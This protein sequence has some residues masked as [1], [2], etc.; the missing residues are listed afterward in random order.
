[1]RLFILFFMIHELLFGALTFATNH[2]KEIDILKSFDIDSSFLYDKELEKIIKDNRKIYKTKHFFKAMD[3]A[4]LFIPMIKNIL[5]NSDVPSEF[6]FLAM[7]ESYFST[8]AYS[9]KRASGL[10]QF[11]PETGRIYGLEINEYIDERRDLVKSTA[12]AV[13]YLEKE[14][15]RFGKWYLAALSYNCGGGRVAR[16][17]KRAGTDDLSVLLDPKKRY[18]PKESRRYIRKIIALALLGTDESFLVES[19]YEFL[20]NRA[21]A[22]SVAAVEVQKGES[23]SRIAKILEMPKKDILKLNRQLKYDFVP[24][25]KDKYTIYIPHVKLSQFKQNYKPSNIEQVYVVYRVKSGDSLYKIGKRYGV[26]Y[27]LIKDFNHLKSNR[28]SLRQKLIIPVSRPNA[29][30]GG[31]YTVKRGD[32]LQSIAHTYKLSIKQLKQI[33]HLKGDMIRI[34]EKLA[35]YD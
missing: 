34:G 23:I 33:N 19:E 18:L 7:T 1:M 11:M 13:K 28:L 5:S 12:A 27:R 6:L 8:K 16:A 10:W 3:D 29:L 35:V 21:N 15:K 2:Q 25:N 20:L 22:Y 32:T 30:K 31:R 9:Q 4:Y 26:P 17:I 14:H 24:P